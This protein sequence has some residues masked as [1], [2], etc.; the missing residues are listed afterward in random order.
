MKEVTSTARRKFSFPS[1]VD[2][3][4]EHPDEQDQ[5]KNDERQTALQSAKAKRKGREGSISQMSEAGGQK[6]DEAPAYAQGYG[7]ASEGMTK[8]KSSTLAPARA[9][10]PSRGMGLR[11][12]DRGQRSE[13]SR[14]RARLRRAKEISGSK[15]RRAP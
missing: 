7:A 15:D 4:S 3:N 2:V 9:H 14:L 8:H 12:E 6:N 13:I 10:N 5:E 1:P 11:S